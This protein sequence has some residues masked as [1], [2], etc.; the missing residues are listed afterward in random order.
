M[1]EQKDRDYQKEYQNQKAYVITL[2]N[3]VLGVWRNL[4]KLC[5]DMKEKDADF[6]SYWTLTR[7]REETPIKF[8]TKMGEYS[9]SIEKLK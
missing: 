6:P 4:K 8:V 1:E 3:A 5:A 2:N 7:K 9:F